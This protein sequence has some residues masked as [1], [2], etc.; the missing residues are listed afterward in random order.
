M[1]SEMEYRMRK[2]NYGQLLRMWLNAFIILFVSDAQMTWWNVFVFVCIFVSA[3]GCWL[4]DALA[5]TGWSLQ[6]TNEYWPT[7]L[8]E[9]SLLGIRDRRI[10]KAKWMALAA[11]VRRTRVETTCD[12]PLKSVPH[13]RTFSAK[14]KQCLRFGNIAGAASSAE[15]LQI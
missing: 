5:E 7:H 3:T 1:Y 13:N 9:M 10:I 8:W 14:I 6:L 2:W 15:D 11:N 4:N 12:E